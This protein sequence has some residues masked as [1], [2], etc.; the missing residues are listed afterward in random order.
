M[1]GHHST[2]AKLLSIRQR[3]NS[4]PT[5][6]LP[7]PH[8]PGSLPTF[9]VHT[10]SRHE[11]LAV[12]QKIFNNHSTKYDRL[13]NLKKLLKCHQ[14][15]ILCHMLLLLVNMLSSSVN[16]SLFLHFW[17]SAAYVNWERVCDGHDE[18]LIINFFPE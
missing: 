9:A 12:S 1:S 5:I 8:P 18:Y 2:P 16:A 14:R 4:R 10:Q 13:V 3:G 15:K 7:A 6:G 17:M 11:A